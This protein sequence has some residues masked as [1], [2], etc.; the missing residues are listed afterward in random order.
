MV[1]VLDDFGEEQE[2]HPSS[3]LVASRPKNNE[4]KSIQG[5]QKNH[6]GSICAPEIG[7]A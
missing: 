1:V 6:V 3:R 4:N 2:P 5:G 7:T